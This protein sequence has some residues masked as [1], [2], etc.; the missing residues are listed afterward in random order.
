MGLRSVLSSGRAQRPGRLGCGTLGR[1][2]G[3]IQEC[4]Q[5]AFLRVLQRFGMMIP[6]GNAGFGD[7][8]S[9]PW[10]LF[11]LVDRC[12][13]RIAPEPSGSDGVYW[14]RDCDTRGMV[15]GW[16]QDPLCLGSWWERRLVW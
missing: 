2:K 14:E 10:M 8:G 3:G 16:L 5:E 1:P 7:S 13:C 4:Q 11:H 6:E 12:S 9:R 15:M